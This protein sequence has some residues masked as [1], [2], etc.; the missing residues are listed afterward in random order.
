VAVSEIS[1]MVF[2]GDHSQV[3]ARAPVLAAGGIPRPADVVVAA[4]MNNLPRPPAGVF[5]GRED[6]LSRLAAGLSGGGGA[7]MAQAV[8]GLGGVGKSELALQYAH[9]H[10]GR[11]APIWWV[12]S[13]DGSQVE[14]GLAALAGRICP[15]LA[16][17][18]T[19]SEAA[20]WAVTW[21]QAHPGWLLILDDVSDPGDVEPMLGQLH[22]GRILLTTRR[23][24][25]CQRIADPVRLDVLAPAP[26]AALITAA[27][28]RTGPR[29]T[30]VAEEIAAELGFLPLALDQAAAYITQARIP[31]A[32]YLELLRQHPTRMYAAGAV[33]GQAQRTIARLWDITLQA[34]SRA[35]RGAAGL[36]RVLACY[37][38]D[39]IARSIIGGRDA[40]PEEDEALGLLASYSMITLTAEAVSMHKLV[41]AAILGAPGD[42]GTT[43]PPQDMAVEWLDEV[44][45]PDPDTNVTAWPFLRA[46][47]PHAEA[48]AGAY[49]AGEE[50]AALARVLNEI[51]VFHRSQGSYQDALRLGFSALD[52][53]QRVYGDGHPEIATFLGNLAATCGKLGRHAEALPL[54]ERALAVTEATLGP[55]HPS[56]AERVG[57]LAQ[58]YSALGRH[59]E[60]LPLK[61]R[62]LAVTE[63]TLGPDHPSTA[64]LVGNLAQTY[65]DLGRH[66]EALPLKEQALAVTEATLGPDHPRTALRLGNLAVTYSALRRDAEALPLDERALAVTEAALGPTTP[67]PQCALATSPGL[68]VLWGG[69]RRHC[70][71]SGERWR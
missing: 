35:D 11:Y 20:G 8:F 17:A 41:Q 10:R 47:I 40:G 68:T 37:A 12:T 67:A 39:A 56:T 65:G 58:T 31:L 61:E 64:E 22:G 23:D 69:M 45:P 71:W 46:L 27:T 2:T 49:P 28:G 51:A 33:G 44:L 7:V 48:V 14:A 66:A 55:D 54:K 5:V 6:V 57:N 18:A 63:A 62:A 9:A 60:A 52:I 1:G 50:P 42:T 21:L 13:E 32:R 19:T 70:R 15:E 34:I 25:G 26:A 29:D 3:D 24:T 30:P 16:L 43:T 59:A 38:P 53:A 4:G 36:L